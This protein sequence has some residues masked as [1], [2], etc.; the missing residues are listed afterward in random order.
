MISQS[1]YRAL[2]LLANAIHPVTTVRRIIK[3]VGCPIIEEELKQFVHPF[4]LIIHRPTK[5]GFYLDQYLKHIIDVTNCQEPKNPVKTTRE[6]LC[7]SPNP[8]GW[9]RMIYKSDE[10]DTFWLY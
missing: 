2:C 8:P 10:F 9:V 3:K 7:K 4:I 6:H 1:L 5:Q